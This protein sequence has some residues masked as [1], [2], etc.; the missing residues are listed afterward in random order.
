MRTSKLFASL[1]AGLILSL[2]SAAWSADVILINLDPPGVGLND[3]TPATPV[4]GNPG[5][6]IGEQ[7][8]NVYNRAAEIWGS[9]LDSDVP[10]FVGATF[11]PL[12]CA[13]TGGVLGAAGP[14]YVFSDFPGAPLADTWYVSAQADAIA[15]AQLIGDID[16]ISF[17]NS[18]IDDNDP[19][20][21]TGTSWYYGYDAN[22]GND[23][24]FLTVVMHEIN[25]GL[26]NLELVSE[27]TG[28][29][30]A[31]RNDVYMYNMLD[32]D[33]NKNWN[34]MT[35][36]ER[37]AS[38]VNSGNLVWDGPS[39]TMEAPNVLGPQTR[40]QIQ[41]PK[42][43]K[44]SYESQPATYGPRLREDGG[45]TGK[46]VVVDDGVGVGSDG[47]EPILNNVKGKIALIDRGACE[48]RLKTF[49]AQVA[50]AKGVVIVNNQATGLP[51][52]GGAD[53]DL[54]TIPSIGVTKDDG[55]AFKAASRRNIVGKMITDPNFLA[56]TQDGYVRLNAP[57]PVQPGS[58]KSHWDP[59]ASPNL[60]ME[61]SINSDLDPT[62][63]LDLSPNLLE[64]IGW[65]LQ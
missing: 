10:I 13:S 57:N 16:I 39:V 20:C 61:P 11:L 38:Q 17:F 5:T 50:G 21:L 44:D 36:A 6:T 33:L 53:L 31:G 58:S 25:H 45:T 34:E 8:V 56:G 60:L 27:G 7:R 37:L 40:L 14:T 62:N 23:I 63:D 43:L 2:S 3:P 41:N 26:G 51:P 15:D 46:M 59:S 28:A 18:D 22:E 54:F 55:D 1:S 35:D 64:D 32:L 49:Y 9:V 30:F 42:G 12:P 52:M 29:P 65:P 24:D 48:F 47:C 19:N 4:G